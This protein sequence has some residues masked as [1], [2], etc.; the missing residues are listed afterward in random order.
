MFII[1]MTDVSLEAKL[2]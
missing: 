2:Q 1:I